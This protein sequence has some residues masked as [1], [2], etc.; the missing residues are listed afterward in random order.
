MGALATV[1]IQRE[2]PWQV[3]AKQVRDRYTMQ[4]AFTW[5][6]SLLWEGVRGREGREKESTEQ[7]GGKRERQRYRERQKAR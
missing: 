3:V 6:V 2:R 1:L 4:T 7:P 5:R